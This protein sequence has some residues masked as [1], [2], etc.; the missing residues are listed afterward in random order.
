MAT[1]FWASSHLKQARVDDLQC[2]DDPQYLDL[3]NIFFAN[4][5]SKLGK[6]LH[7]RQRVICTTT[8][9]FR[10]FYLKNSYCEADPFIVIAAC[11]YV[12]AK[13]EESPVYIY[14]T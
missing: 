3:L 6:K 4:V 5:I 8:I 14:K 9:F 10:W 13:S 12:A 1:D 11:C 7:L 2:V